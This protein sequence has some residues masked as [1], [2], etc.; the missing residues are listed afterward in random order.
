MTIRMARRDLL[1]AGMA[2][3]LPTA[4]RAAVLANV[5]IGKDGWLFP[6]WEDIRHTNLARRRTQTQLLGQAA[7]ILRQAG[8]ATTFVLTPHKAR[9]AAEFLPDD[10][11]PDAAFGDAY[12]LAM[13]DLRQSGALVPDLASVLLAGHKAPGEPV[14][15]KADTHW[16]ANGAELAA[17]EIAK[18]I[19][20]QLPAAKG[21]GGISLGAYTSHVHAGD[22]VNLLPDSEKSKYPPQKFRLYRASEARS[23]G[24]NQGGLID[25]SAADLVVIGNSYTQPYFGFPLVLSSQLARPVDL[26]WKTARNGPYRTILD[27]L[28]SPMFRSS[29]PAMLVWHVM[30]GVLEWSPDNVSAWADAAMAPQAFL[31]TL[32]KAVARG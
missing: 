12:G 24:D 1:T 26:S 32:R 20:P 18:A 2:S 10:F 14:F 17:I 5:V 31:D 30:E 25:D 27:Y 7:Q 8:I 4:S 23:G 3:L 15:F 6:A 19:K 11:R 13:A 21:K 9:V 28:A 29:R 22:L 16:T